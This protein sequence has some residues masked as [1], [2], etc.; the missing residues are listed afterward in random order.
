MKKYLALLSVVALLTLVAAPA[1][2]ACEKGKWAGAGMVMCKCFDKKLGLTD[3]QQKK[4]DALRQKTEKKAAA[5]MKKLKV[6]I[7]EMKALWTAA[8]PSRK[9]ILAK[10]AQIRKIKQKLGVIKVDAHLAILKILTAEQKQTLIK[11][12]ETC[13]T[14]GA[15]PKGCDCPTCKGKA[16]TEPPAEEKKPGCKGCPG[17]CPHH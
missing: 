6:K 10:Q 14:G 11:E 2:L 16:A 15:C 1:A 5:H 17:D 4:L 3:D 8:K 9:A 12:K 13:C 7:P